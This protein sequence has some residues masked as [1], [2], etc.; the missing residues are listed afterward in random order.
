[1]QGFLRRYKNRYTMQ[2]FADCNTQSATQKENFKFFLQVPKNG[3]TIQGF[4]DRSEQ[5]LK[6]LIF[7][8]SLT[9]YSR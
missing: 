9:R 5:N 4:A 8:A 3:A 6:K 7:K 2:F 1:M